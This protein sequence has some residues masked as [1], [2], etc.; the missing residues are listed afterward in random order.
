MISPQPQLVYYC[1]HRIIK[2]NTL[3]CFVGLKPNI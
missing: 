3:I 2:F 1:L